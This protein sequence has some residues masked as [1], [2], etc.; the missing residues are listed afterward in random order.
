MISEK[1]FEYIR[2]KVWGKNKELWA[3]N[4]ALKI[5]LSW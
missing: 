3:S 4:L 5:F 1:Y 2:Q